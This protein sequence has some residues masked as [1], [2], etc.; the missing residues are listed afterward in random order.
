MDEIGK[1]KEYTSQDLNRSLSDSEHLGDSHQDEYTVHKAGNTGPDEPE[2][3]G[4]PL[5]DLKNSHKYKP[6][7]SSLEETRD[8]SVFV[9]YPFHYQ[10]DTLPTPYPP[11]SKDKWDGQHVRMPFS[12][13]NEYPQDDKNGSVQLTKRWSMIEKA[14]RQNIKGSFELEEAILSYN[15]RYSNKWK[16]TAFHYYFNKTLKADERDTFFSTTLKLLVRL[17][18]ELPK[19]CTKPIP[20]LKAGEKKSL[21]FS[22]L[23]VAS[24]L[25]NAFF[26]TF[27]RRNSRARGTEYASYPDINFNNLY[28]AEPHSIPRKV[29]KLKCILNYFNRVL[30][31]YPTGLV[32]FTRKVEKEHDWSNDQEMLTK[33]HVS[34]SGTIE[35][36]GKGMLQVDFAN[37]YIGGGVLGHGCVQEEIR[38]LICPEMIVARLFTEVL[39]PLECL[40][41]TGCE[42]F[43]KYTGYADTFQ[44][45]GDFVDTTPRDSWGR[46]CTEVVAIDALVFHGDYKK[47]FQR[48]NIRREL[49]KA[50]CGFS[51]KVIENSRT[52]VCTGNWGMWCLWRRQQLK[53][54]IQVVAAS[55][56]KRDVCY[57]TFG[58]MEL[59]ESLYEI[60]KLLCDSNRT[61]EEVVTLME[62]YLHSSHRH[63]LFDY[64]RAVHKGYQEQ[65]NL[66]D[67]DDGSHESGWDN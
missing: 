23:Q 58:D 31:K 49:N 5:V 30:H 63:S 66:P 53:S 22:Q 38:F 29:Q 1:I 42:Q 45:A 52:A 61:I 50:F 27:P 12:Q 9:K 48:T 25:A 32:T 59:T 44:W 34:S 8:H 10:E 28:H 64:I 24:L 14:L 2:W 18:L 36:D 56:A 43:S 54:L 4:T 35:D 65:N 13:H 57:F 62:R 41:M 16:F 3:R 19:L 47:Q 26:C 60:H 40:V 39:E 21:T 11:Q 46:R 20:L 55:A 33:L 6:A 7:L 37:K 51:T 15:Q 17:A 67:C